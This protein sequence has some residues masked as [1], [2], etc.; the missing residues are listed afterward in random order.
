MEKIIKTLLWNAS[1][2]NKKIANFNFKELYYELYKV[3]NKSDF[4]KL[5]GAWDNVGTFFK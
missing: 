4:S 1:F 5:L 2:E 3:K